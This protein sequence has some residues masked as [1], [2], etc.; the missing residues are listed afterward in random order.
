MTV[1]VISTALVSVGL[2][3][4]ADGPFSI[5]VHPVFLGIDIDIK[6]G[7]LHS[8]WVWSALPLLIS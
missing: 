7:A 2:T 6:F 1:L 8:H 5:V 4:P 3:A